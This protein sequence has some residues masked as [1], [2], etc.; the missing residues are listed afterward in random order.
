MTRPKRTI[1]KVLVLSDAARAVHRQKVGRLAAKDTPPCKEGKWDLP[2]SIIQLA[3]RSVMLR[4]SMEEIE[5][6]IAELVDIHRSENGN[7][8]T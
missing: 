7:A 8:Y 5:T 2:E 1:H 6:L 4:R 3:I